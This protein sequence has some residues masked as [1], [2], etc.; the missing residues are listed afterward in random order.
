MA[1]ITLFTGKIVDSVIFKRPRTISGC[2]SAEL[3]ILMYCQKQ[4]TIMFAQFFTLHY[5]I[6]AFS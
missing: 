4:S 2:Y 5:S 3:D 1:K 6:Q